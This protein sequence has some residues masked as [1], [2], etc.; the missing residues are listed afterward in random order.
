MSIMPKIFL[1]GETRIDDIGLMQCLIHLGAEEWA[2]DASND[3]SR[4]L[5]FAGRLCYKSFIPGLNPNV[6]KV[7]EGNEPYLRNIL[8]QRHGSVFEHAHVSIVFCDV[9]R[10]FT[11]ELVRHRAGVAISQ[12]SQRFVRLDDFEV[13]IPNL[14]PALHEIADI[15]LPG[16]TASPEERSRWVQDQ[17]QSFVDEFEEACD[18]TESRIKM[19]IDNWHLDDPDVTFNVKKKLT[20]ALRRMVPGGVTTNI[21][22]TANH[23][24][25]RHILAMR[26]NSGAEIEIHEVMTQVAEMLH[27]RYPALYQDMSRSGTIGIPGVPHQISFEFDKI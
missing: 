27:Y 25:W 5:E 9:S 3:A 15:I 12:E 14:T 22:V 23:R 1:V 11:H 2:T 19:L 24:A 10:I 8:S 13:Y 26:A 16:T 4:L 7:R 18:Q 6:T 20:S 21:M 17:Q